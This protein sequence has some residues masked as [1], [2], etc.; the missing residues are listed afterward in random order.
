MRLKMQA[1]HDFGSTNG[2]VLNAVEQL[3][4]F[5]LRE[6]NVQRDSFSLTPLTC[7]FKSAA[8]GSMALTRS[9]MAL[10]FSPP[11]L[12]TGR[13]EIDGVVQLVSNTRC[14]LTDGSELFRCTSCCCADWSSSRVV[15]MLA[16]TSEISRSIA[17]TFFGSCSARAPCVR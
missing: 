12:R 17:D 10:R 8:A 15:R 6:L 9:M 16:L 4:D 14:Q 3:L 5:L 2:A 1:F 7:S 13:N 11:Q